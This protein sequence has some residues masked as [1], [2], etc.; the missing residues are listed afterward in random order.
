MC[1]GPWAF[2]W[3]AGMVVLFFI[4]SWIVMLLWNATL[5][6]I[7]AFKTLTYWQAVRLLLL[8]WILFGGWNCCLRGFGRS[9]Y[10][11]TCGTYGHEKYYGHGKAYWHGGDYEQEEPAMTE[12][13][14]E[15]E[16]PPMPMKT[17]KKK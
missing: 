7:S 6:L 9:S 15:M 1:C 16:K 3:I 2:A 17:P 11:P 13:S 4:A 8:T 10:C 12:K 14:A 5:P